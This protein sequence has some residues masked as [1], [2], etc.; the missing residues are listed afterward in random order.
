[1]QPCGDVGSDVGVALNEPH[2]TLRDGTPVLIRQLVAE[3]AAL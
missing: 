2:S 3:D 1:M